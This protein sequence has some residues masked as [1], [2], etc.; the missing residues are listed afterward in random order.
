MNSS[1]GS[2]ADDSLSS[3]QLKMLRVST[4]TNSVLDGCVTLAFLLVV[5]WKTGTRSN[6]TFSRHCKVTMVLFFAFLLSTDIKDVYLAV[7]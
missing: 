1:S 5:L 2:E 6:R 7:N 4:W 3:L